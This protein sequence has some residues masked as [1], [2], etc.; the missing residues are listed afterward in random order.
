MPCDYA[1]DVER[2]L[3]QTRLWGSVTPADLLDVRDRMA[4]DPAYGP[5]LSILI[6]MREVERFALTTGDVQVLA[7]TSKFGQGSRRAFVASSP[8]S[9]GLARMFQSY[10]EINDGLE[11]TAVFETME[12][13][14]VWLTTPSAEQP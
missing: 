5:H 3:V 14:E 4:V 12:A 8:S 6:D 7:R 13:A 11:E 2:G 9:F 10:R 1:I